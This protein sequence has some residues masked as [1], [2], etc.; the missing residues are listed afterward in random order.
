VATPLKEEEI[1]KKLDEIISMRGKRGIN[2][3]NQLECLNMLRQHVKQQNLN[4]KIILIQ[5]TVSFDYH[6]KKNDYFKLETWTRY[7]TNIFFSTYF[8]SPL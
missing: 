8:F 6:H 2:Y 4:I 3:Q 1:F 7:I 5:I